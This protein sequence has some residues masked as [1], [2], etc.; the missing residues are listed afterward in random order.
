MVGINA[1]GFG[2][3]VEEVVDYFPT[4]YREYVWPPASVKKLASSASRVHQ[5]REVDVAHDD[6]G[7][8]MSDPSLGRPRTYADD[9]LH[10]R[11]NSRV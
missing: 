4:V 1:A 11:C 8:V 10:V 6:I 2:F 9:P 7:C 5:R 3:S